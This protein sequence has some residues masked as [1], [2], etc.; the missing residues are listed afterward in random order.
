MWRLDALLRGILNKKANTVKI[1]N[2]IEHGR[3]I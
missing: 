2:N 1:A 3:F